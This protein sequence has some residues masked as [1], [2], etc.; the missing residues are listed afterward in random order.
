M[1]KSESQ[2]FINKPIIT[3]DSEYNFIRFRC[4]CRRDLLDWK[5]IS[6][7]ELE[8]AAMVAWRELLIAT[9]IIPKFNQAIFDSLIIVDFQNIQKLF[10]DLEWLAIYDITEKEFG[11]WVTF[12]AF[13]NHW[14]E[15]EIRLMPVPNIIY[16][17]ERAAKFYEQSVPKY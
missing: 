5:E 14:Q 8:G 1:V 17:Q 11:Q 10:Y 7:S 12:L 16:Y 15:S 2:I 4:P 13:I 9:S 6:E 3:G